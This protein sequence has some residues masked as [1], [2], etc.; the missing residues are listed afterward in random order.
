MAVP[1]LRIRR[2]NDQTP[3]PDGR[4]ILY[5]MT[6]SRRGAWNFGL[7]RAVEWA[8]RYQRPLLVLEAVRCGYKW[9]SDRFQQFVVEGMEQNERWFAERSTAYYPY[10]EPAEGAGRGLIERLAQ[11]ACVVVTD[12]YPC[13][14]LPRMASLTARRLDVLVE[15]VDSNGLVPMRATE[16]VFTMAHSFRRWIQKNI[17]PYL[18]EFPD[19]DPLAGATLPRLDRMPADVER[20]WPRSPVARLAAAR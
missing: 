20:Q 14:F 7:Q 6:A 12:D 3:R 4:Y 19:P 15:T 11:D 10:V 16:Q 1:D 18:A 5:W 8:R 2:L 13:F 17:K 9:A